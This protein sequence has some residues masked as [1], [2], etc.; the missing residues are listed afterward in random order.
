M[1][2]RLLTAAAWS[3]AAAAL[4]ALNMATLQSE[5]APA[6]Q[7]NAD[8]G[9]AQIARGRYLVTIGACNDCHTPFKLGANGPEP[10]M[11]R[12]LSGHPQQAVFPPPPLPAEGSPWIQTGAATNTAWAGPWGISYTT[13]LTPDK[14][15]GMGDWTSGEFIAAMRSGRHRGRGRAILPPMP[16]PGWSQATEEDLAAIFAYLQSIPAL[17]NQ[18]PEALIAPPPPAP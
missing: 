17:K 13:N 4:L 8:A 15:T 2:I 9:Q 10:D 14:E 5:A 18:V 16:W 11:T 12:M 7:A 6:D 1:K 3:A